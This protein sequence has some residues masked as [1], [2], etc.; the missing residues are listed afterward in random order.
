MI[1]ESSH[2]SSLVL[3]AVFIISYQPLLNLYQESSVTTIYSC[4]QTPIM[5]MVI[6]LSDDHFHISSF[7]ISLFPISD[8]PFLLLYRPLLYSH[9]TPLPLVTCTVLLRARMQLLQREE[10]RSRQTSVRVL[11]H[12]RSGGHLLL[13]N[14]KC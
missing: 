9:Q 3:H 5:E 7:P 1:C 8:F 6:T 14:H 12:S 10:L 11:L 4:A 2:N 13:L